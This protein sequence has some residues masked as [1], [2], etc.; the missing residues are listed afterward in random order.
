MLAVHSIAWI[1]NRQNVNHVGK[2]C[3]PLLIQ[4]ST[5]GLPWTQDSVCSKMAALAVIV[6]DAA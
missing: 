3:K 4:I 1:Q 2:Y 5:K 6:G